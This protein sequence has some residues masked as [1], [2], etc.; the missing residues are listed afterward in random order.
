MFILPHTG[1]L[2]SARILQFEVGGRGSESHIFGE[3]GV[4]EKSRGWHNY[5]GGDQVGLDFLA[6]KYPFW[7]FLSGKLSFFHT[8]FPQIRKFSSLPK[9]MT[10]FSVL[11]LIFWHF[12]PILQIL[13]DIRSK[14]P[15]KNP[16][17]VRKPQNLVFL[18]KKTQRPDFLRK[19][20]IWSFCTRNGNADN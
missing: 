5:R 1:I 19:T 6:K 17:F 11:Q 9:P 8:F 13:S 3:V 7:T 10:F 14:T 18:R 20:Q 4:D 16:D 2:P 12:T 15:E